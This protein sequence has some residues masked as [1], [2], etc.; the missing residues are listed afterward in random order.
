MPD[1]NPQ[2]RTTPPEIELPAGDFGAYIFDCD[3]TLADSMPLHWRS[4]R[5]ALAQ[6]GAPFD[7]DWAL[8]MRIAGMG[9]ENTV[10]WLNREYDVDLDPAAVVHTKETFYMNHVEEVRPLGPVARFADQ[11]EARGLLWNVASGSPRT[12]LDRTLRAIGYH[13]VIPRS[14]ARED[15]AHGKPAPDTFLLAAERLGVEPARCLVF[16]DADLGIEAAH[17]AGMQAV[18][19]EPAEP[20]IPPA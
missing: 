12:V 9:L 19:I 18:K 14:V 4:W 16:E 6:H 8:Q 20:D 10:E 11:A 17:R 1:P 5:H 15:V 2:G 3:G 7:F 13:Q